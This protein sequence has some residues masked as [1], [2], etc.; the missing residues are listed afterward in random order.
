MKSKLSDTSLCDVVDFH[1]HILHGVDHGSES[2][3]M[4]LSQIKIAKSYSV[5][6]IL[7]TPHFYPNLHTLSSFLKLRDSAAL[8]LKKQISDNSVEIKLGAE[9]L[10]CE[11]L[12]RFP[13]L[14]KLCFSG[15]KYI[16]LELPT[17]DFLEEY[18]VTAGY[19]ADMGYEIILAHAD[20]YPARA[21][22]IM[23]D[24]GVKTLQLNAYSISSL[25]KK[26]S[27][28]NWIDRGLVSSIGSDIHGASRFPYKKFQAAKGR[29]GDLLVPIK[30]SSDKIWD[31]IGNI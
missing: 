14:E 4:S 25:F 13:G 1:S 31:K 6:R 10:I 28:W 3:K 12:E 15:T 2:M 26:K 24:Y 18:A 27:V 17:D 16:M 30:E 20:R 19:I 22:E 23:L 29:L 8:D 9:V 5:N 7:A 11:G 21:V